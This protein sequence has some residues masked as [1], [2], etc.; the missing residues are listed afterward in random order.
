MLASRD[1][2]VP[3]Y[4]TSTDVLRFKNSYHTAFRK[5]EVSGASVALAPQSFVCPLSYSVIRC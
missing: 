1:A 4:T 5:P 3:H 2:T